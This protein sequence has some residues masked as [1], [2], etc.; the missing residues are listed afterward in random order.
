MTV[1]DLHD[2]STRGMTSANADRLRE[3]GGSLVFETQLRRKDGTPILVE[4]SARLIGEPGSERYISVHRD[5]TERKAAE[6][7][8]EAYRQHLEAMVEDRTAELSAVNEELAATN[9]ELTSLNEELAVTNEEFASVNEELQNTNAELHAAT[10]AKSEFMANMS[11]ELRTPLNSIIGFAGVMLQGL[12]GD[13][14]QE[15]KA[16]LKMIRRSGERLLALISDIL[17]LSRIESGRAALRPTDIDLGEL[18]ASAVATV[19]PLADEDGLDLEIARVPDGLRLRTDEQ[20]VHQVL[21]NLL[22][23][24]IKFTDS[25]SVSLEVA[26]P[27]DS[28]IVFKVSDTGVGIA[29]EDLAE[30][31]EEFV[32]IPRHGAKPE[33]TGLGLAI[34]RRLAVMLGG[35]LTATSVVGEGS[36]FTLVLPSDGTEVA[37]GDGSPNA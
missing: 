23:N 36:T 26:A 3:A 14:T 7:E 20:K 6:Q 19:Q 33:G 24:A 31:F 12:T 1:A 17:D 22:A 9:E 27:S 4:S 13:M 30:I 18:V 10:T 21:V 29:P 28:T 11:H 8:L 37:P 2:P 32:Q 35:T 34:S 25:G 16:Q 15:Q 5:I